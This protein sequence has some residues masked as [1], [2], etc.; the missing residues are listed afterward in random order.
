M[1]EK[2]STISIG[3]TKISE[4][5][6]LN[7]ARKII[8][9]NGLE[10][11]KDNLMKYSGINSKRTLETVLLAERS[12]GTISID[13]NIDKD[14]DTTILDFKSD[15]FSIEEEVLKNEQIRSLYISISNLSNDEQYLIIYS[16]GLLGKDK[17][18][19]KEMALYLKVSENTII[20]RKNA[21]KDKLRVMMEPLVAWYCL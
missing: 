7:N 11:T 1:R 15:D 17:K 9:E 13:S 6:K 19:N 20:N 16:Y 12:N 10:E 21:I 8:R 3:T 4:I 14:S 5:K 18:S 2:Q